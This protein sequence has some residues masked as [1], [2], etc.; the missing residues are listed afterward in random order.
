VDLRRLRYFVAVA[1]ELHFGKAAA[2]LHISAPPLSQRIK[3]LERELGVELFERTSRKVMLTSAGE[4]LLPEA[5]R[6]LAA[7]ARFQAAADEIVARIPTLT[8]G[9]SHGSEP[10]VMTAI[11]RFHAE[12]PEITVRSDGLTSA[13]IYEG[14]AAG[15]LDIGVARGPVPADRSLPHTEL[16]DVAVDHIAIPIGHPLADAA[17]VAPADLD[18]E[19]LLIVDRDDS[20]GVHDE[21][22]A[23][24]AD[25]GVSPRFV[26][27]AATQ[28]ERALDMVAVGT[29]F[30]WLNR[31]QAERHRDRPDVAIRPLSEP[32]RRDH[33]VVAW[34]AETRHPTVAPLV[35]AV[36]DTFAE[37]TAG[38]R[39]DAKREN[40]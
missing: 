13:R 32:V 30:G 4:S 28:I 12:H 36:V 29:G 2:R 33:F 16:P 26:D 8:V 34:S 17:V 24:F 19:P 37:A 39:R 14:L 10:E 20:L 40:P 23:F 27:H 21:S 6:V 31:G 25:R 35:R 1:E 11:N 9:Y 3:E 38:E 22:V 15:R 7:A 5:R 18:G